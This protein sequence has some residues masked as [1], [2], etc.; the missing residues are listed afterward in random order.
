MSTIDDLPDDVLIE[1]FGSYV[2]KIQD[3][4]LHQF[5]VYHSRRKRRKPKKIESWKPLVHVCRRWRDLVFGSP[6]SLNLQLYCGPGRLTRRS[7]DVWPPFPVLIKGDVPKV[8]EDNV[9][10]GLKHRI[11]QIYLRFAQCS[12]SQHKRLWT[13]MRAPFP[14]LTALFMSSEGASFTFPPLPVIPDSF[15][16]GSAPHLLCLD[17]DGI[18]FPGLLKLLLS[19]THLVKLHLRNIPHFGEISPEA[20]ATCL[21]TLS[22]LESLHLGFECLKSH[23]NYKM[24]PPFPPTRTVLPSLNIF[25]FRGLCEYFEK[26][27]TLIDTPHELYR[28]STEIFHVIDSNS[29]SDFTKFIS[30][31][32]ILGTCDEARFIFDEGRV[33]LKISQPHLRPEASDC[34]IVELKLLFPGLQLSTLAQIY[35]SLLRPVSTI[36]NLFIYDV[37]YPP[38]R[39]ENDIENT[40]NTE[41]LDLLLSFPAIKNL[42]VAKRIAPRIAL[43]LQEI[44]GGGTTEVL[45]ALENFYLEGFQENHYLRRLGGIRQ[46]VS[47]RR[48]TGPPVAISAWHR[49]ERKSH[50]D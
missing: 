33:L 12:A 5:F 7:L 23:P 37:Q 43:A 30:R 16:G 44:T 14:E 36:D 26:F 8:L 41:W 40:E 34:R 20:M 9:I 19:C 31:T 25:H 6:R 21:S 13:Q 2:A 45:S 27:V 42:Y 11:S 50:R 32:P 35:T 1:I 15:L 29:T 49:I 38:L 10:P 47:A 18:V 28:L 3:P 39:R 46:F 22:S 24:R 48:L 17:L 4:R